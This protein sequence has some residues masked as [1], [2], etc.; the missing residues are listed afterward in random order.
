MLNSKKTISINFVDFWS[1]C[2]YENLHFIKLIKED[3]DIVLSDKP[4]YL[5]CSCFGY[6]HFKYNDTI[7]I[8]YSGENLAC[9]FNLYDYAMSS[10]YLTLNDRHI[11]VPEWLPKNL[12][13]VSKME[14]EKEKYPDLSNKKFCNFLY[15][16]KYCAHP[17]RQDFFNKLSKYKKV[18]SGG[19][20]L[21]NLGF[22]VEN[23][24]DFIK[25]YKFTIAIENS[26]V[27]GYVTE[28]LR[29]PILCGSMP[30]YYGDPLVGK[31]FNTNSFVNLRDFKSLDEAIDYIVEL[32]KNDDLYYEKY[33]L[34]CFVNQNVE[35]FY[36]N[37]IKN[38]F[39]NIFNQD[40]NMAK[41]VTKYG[42]NK[43][44][45][46]QHCLPPP[47]TKRKNRLFI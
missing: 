36:R 10:Y 31:E 47:P 44:Y 43:F 39:K 40:K 1:G 29:D 25:D 37:R 12:S 38:F 42:F 13:E 46:S 24:S 3:Y 33:M 19:S 21:N 8:F 17:L 14:F 18:D 16:N 27:E 45:L 41:K 20:L 9:D 15:S 4:D 34:P 23:K 2:K 26:F 32:D 5:F 11:R 35:D 7:K 28:K 6:D 30:L 22:K